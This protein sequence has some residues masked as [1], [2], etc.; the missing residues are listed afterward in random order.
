MQETMVHPS[1][2]V[3]IRTWEELLRKYYKARLNEVAIEYPDTRSLAVSYWDL[4][5]HS[6]GLAEHLLEFPT[7]VLAAAHKAVRALD[8]PLPETPRL[9]V[10]VRDLPEQ[11]RVD[12]RHLRSKHLNRFV[13]ISGLVKRA[14]DVRPRLEDAVFRCLRCNAAITEA[15]DE[16][17]TM[18]EPLQCYEDQ[19]GCGHSSGFKLVSEKSRFVDAQKLEVQESPEQ[20]R[21]GEQ[22]Q[23]LVLFVEDD[24]CGQVAPGDRIVAN[25]ILR[26]VP[27]K[28]GNA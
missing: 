2:E 15:Q 27:K 5:R 24:L 4:D 17:N 10:R 26:A 18:K 7:A 22:P 9:H 25:G 14:S 20:L 11:A 23:R 16:F 13:A 12:I 21:G 1:E 28:Q 3:L 6:Q 19:G 8:T